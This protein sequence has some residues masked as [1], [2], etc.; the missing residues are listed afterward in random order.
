M[1]SERGPP[2]QL[3]SIAEIGEIRSKIFQKLESIFQK[4][5][6]YISFMT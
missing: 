3:C 6:G 5:T 2:T 4:K 1:N